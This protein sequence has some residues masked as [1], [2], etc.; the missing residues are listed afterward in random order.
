M[1]LRSRLERL[2]PRG[3]PWLG[4]LSD[5]ELH[6]RLTDLFRK[7]PDDPALPAEVRADLTDEIADLEAAR[8]GCDAGRGARIRAYLVAQARR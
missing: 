4:D 8:I 1:T 3:A 7:R 6:A 2:E 5:E